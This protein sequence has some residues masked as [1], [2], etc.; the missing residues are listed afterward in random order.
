MSLHRSVFQCIRA[1][2]LF[3]IEFVPTIQILPFKFSTSFS[4]LSLYSEPNLILRPYFLAGSDERE[5]S[6]TN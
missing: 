1:A 6:A 3:V 5:H 2:C 4:D